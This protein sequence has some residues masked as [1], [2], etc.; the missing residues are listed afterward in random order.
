M[1]KL[2]FYLV[3]LIYIIIVNISI[4]L[5]NRAHHYTQAYYY[6]VKLMQLPSVKR[7]GSKKQNSINFP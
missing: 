2:A 3:K 6:L 5:H 7:N 1:I 4:L